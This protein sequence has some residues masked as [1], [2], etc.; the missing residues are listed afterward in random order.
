[1]ARLSA[2]GR[3][4]TGC[5]AAAATREEN[6]ADAGRLIA[7]STRLRCPETVIARVHGAAM[8]GGMGLVAACDLAVAAP[9]AVFGFSEVRLG[10]APAMIFPYLLRKIA[11]HHLL[12]AALTGERFSAHAREMGLVNEVAEDLDA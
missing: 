9:D 1:M 4:W 2:L 11:R 8:G 7:T 10:L 6:R 3:I 5:A 12:Q